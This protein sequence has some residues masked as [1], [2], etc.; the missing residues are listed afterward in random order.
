[1]RADERSAWKKRIGS[2]TRSSN[3]SLLGN[4]GRRIFRFHPPPPPLLLS[5]TAVEYFIIRKFV[6]RH[7]GVLSSLG[8]ISLLETLFPR[9]S[10]NLGNSPPTT[11]A[12]DAN[13]LP[14]VHRSANRKGRKGRKTLNLEKALNPFL[15]LVRITQTRFDLRADKELR[16]SPRRIAT[17]A[18]YCSPLFSKQTYRI[19]RIRYNFIFVAMYK[20]ITYEII[21]L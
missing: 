12:G 9:C 19:D 13:Y 21:S 20:E 18:F 14:R 5:P 16:A 1:M 6:R 10:S 3:I 11:L 7:S 2:R 4:I 17:I 8:N 15:T